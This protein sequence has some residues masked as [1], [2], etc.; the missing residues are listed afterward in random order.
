MSS[1]HNRWNCIFLVLVALPAIIFAALQEEVEP[2]LKSRPRYDFV[3]IVVYEIAILLLLFV[4]VLVENGIQ[5]TK[6]LVKP[7]A[8]SIIK[9]SILKHTEN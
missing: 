5:A 6:S 3:E 9:C 8:N 4:F 1:V 7:F 2:F